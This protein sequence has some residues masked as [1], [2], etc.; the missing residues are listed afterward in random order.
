MQLLR[1]N[2]RHP[3]CVETSDVQSVVMDTTTTP[4]QLVVFRSNLF[5]ETIGVKFGG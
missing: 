3:M 5:N 2:K 4:V 1:E